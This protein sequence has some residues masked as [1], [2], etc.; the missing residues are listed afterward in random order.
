M[1]GFHR[2]NKFLVN[3]R[4]RDTKE[5]LSYLLS[6][7]PSEHILLSQFIPVLTVPTDFISQKILIPFFAKVF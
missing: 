4:D 2:E 7:L 3:R 5:L 1:T 6:N